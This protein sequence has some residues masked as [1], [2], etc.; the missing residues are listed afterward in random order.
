MRRTPAKE[1]RRQTPFIS[2]RVEPVRF[3]LSRNLI[4][5]ISSREGS[6]RSDFSIVIVIYMW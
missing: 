2:W 4:E 1:V 5:C 6:R 3:I